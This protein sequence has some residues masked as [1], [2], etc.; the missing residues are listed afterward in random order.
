MM[1]FLL[2]N[3]RYGT[4]IGHRFHLPIP[5]IGY[6]KPTNGNLKQ[7]TDFIKSKNPDIIGL[8]EVDS[9]SF[10]SDKQ[11]QAADIAREMKHYHVFQTKYPAQ[12]LVQRI[13]VLNKQGN[14]FLTNQKVKA[15][16]FHYLNEGVKRLVI[17]LELEKLT[18]FLVHLSIKFRHRQNQLRDLHSII[19][20]VKNP[21]IVAGDF[22]VFW[23]DQEIQLFLAATGLKNV[24]GNGQPS[25]PSRSPRRQLDYILHSPEIHPVDFY[26]PQVKLSDHVP[27]V[28]DFEIRHNYR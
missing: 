19:K 10:R 25:H 27:L 3:I 26:L 20:T 28:F 5:Y 14:A 21:V 24:N 23:G 15:E 13:P 12:S 4:G 11:N 6:L 1:R 8:V 7:I 16:K 22:N 9:G 18:I 17:E 2:Y